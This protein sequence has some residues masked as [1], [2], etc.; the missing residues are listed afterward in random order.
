MASVTAT[1]DSSRGLVRLDID[2]SSD[3]TT[4]AVV[5]NRT[6]PEIR[7]HVVFLS[8]GFAVVYDTEMPL[9][10]PITYEVRPNGAAAPITAGP[11][12][13]DLPDGAGSGW[14]R[15]PL[16]PCHDLEIPGCWEDD[17]EC[18]PAVRGILWLEHGTQEYAGRSVALAIENR[19]RPVSMAHVRS[20]MTTV[21]Q[22]YT[23]TFAER[24]RMLA[25]LKPGSV[26]LFQ[27]D[28]S[29]GVPDVYLHVG[30]VSVDR[31]FPDHRDQL[32]LFTVPV[33]VVDAPSGKPDG[34]CGTRWMDLC[35]TTWNAAEAAGVTW[36]EIMQG[37]LA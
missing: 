18:D 21:L 36:M 2:I 16:R 5:I 22:F 31:E 37:E 29:Y 12:T 13:V 26:L 27:F 30:D 4:T 28:A 34:P 33:V 1:A 25:L 10:V 9:G 6:P 3:P 7:Q 20:D 14:L 32:R 11:V 17:P 35:G 8:G 15:D 24:D 23:P 19:R